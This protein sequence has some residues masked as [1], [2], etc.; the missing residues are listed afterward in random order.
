MKKG[1]KVLIGF[2]AAL[3]VCGVILALPPVWDRA[4]YYGRE[5][6]AEIKYALFPPAEA[7]FTPGE[8]DPGYVATSVAATI[9]SSFPSPTATQSTPVATAEPTPTRTPLPPY[10]YLDGIT[11]EPQLWNNCGPA[12][13]SM[14]LSFYKWGHTQVDTAAVLKPNQRDKNVMPYEMVDFV[15]TYTDYNALMR[16]GG[17]LQTLKT[18]VN[19]GFPV[20]VEKGFEPADLKREGWMGHF[21]LII[22]YDDARQ[23]LITQDSYLLVHEDYDTSTPGFEVTYADMEKNWR[24]FNFVFLVV[25]APE[26]QNDVLNALGPLAD[27]TLAYQIAYQRALKETTTLTDPRDIFFAW[28]NTGTSLVYLRDYAGAASAYDTAYSVYPNIDTASRPWRMLWYQ[29]GPYYAYYYS[30]RYQDVIDLANHTLDAMSEPVLEESYHW[31]ALAK[32]ALGDRSGAVADFR[33]AL[34]VH[35]NFGP[36]LYQLQQLGET[37]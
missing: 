4:V 28:F 31:R 12:T 5:I 15:N 9:Q 34:D 19:A 33:K 2:A 30:G 37:P 13:L 16:M 35:E 29:T 17:D 24:A 14:Y 18:L 26:K 1:V 8:S 7:V 10:A 21:N 20:M 3:I 22:G 6:F 32:L 11:P 23:I 27:E 36:S 25:Y